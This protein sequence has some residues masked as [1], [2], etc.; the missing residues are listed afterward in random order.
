MEIFKHFTSLHRYDS[1]GFYGD[2]FM[3]TQ[4]PSSD[5]L[6]V[7]SFSWTKLQV[8]SNEPFHGLFHHS[9]QV[10]KNMLIIY[11]GINSFNFPMG[12]IY[13]LD[14]DSFYFKKIA[15]KIPP[16]KVSSPLLLQQQQQNSPV[17]AHSPVSAV[18]NFNTSNFPEARYGHASCIAQ[19]KY[20]IFGGCDKVKDLTDIFYFDLLELREV[21]YDDLD[22][23]LV[24]QRE[25]FFSFP[26]DEK[27]IV[28]MQAFIT[29]NGQSLL[30]MT[31]K[32]QRNN[33]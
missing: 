9:A 17:S 21:F 22:Q 3:Y 31:G 23:E 4:L 33:N 14:F 28:Y 29:S 13:A 6:L 20:Y 32:A 26:N 1:Y 30:Y 12:N 15:V 16:Q 27:G 10:Y 18:A 7:K 19:D 2:C 11:G 5:S 24:W 25:H 8:I